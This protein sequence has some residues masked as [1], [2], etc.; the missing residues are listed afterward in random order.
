MIVNR[1]TLITSIIQQAMNNRGK[2]GI[3]W[4]VHFQQP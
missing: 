3:L 1:K 4:V 2:Q